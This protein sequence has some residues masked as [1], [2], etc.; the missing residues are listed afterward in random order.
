MVPGRETSRTAT[1]IAP[2]VINGLTLRTART[3]VPERILLTDE[4]VVVLRDD[5]ACGASRHRFSTSP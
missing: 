3:H 1:A 5:A 4:A 2:S